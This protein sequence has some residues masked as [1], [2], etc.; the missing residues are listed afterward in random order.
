M[1]NKLTI[2]LPKGRLAELSMEYF[3][4]LGITSSEMEKESRKLVFPSDCGN[5]EFILVR[6]SDVPVY[7]EH[8]AA[9]MGVVGKDTLLEYGSDVYEP[10]DLGFG[11]CRMCIAK[12][13]DKDINLNFEEWGNLRVA[14]KFENVAK[15]Y[16][17]KKGINA[18]IIKLYGSIE[19]AP[20]LG[21]SDVIV[22][23]VSS[24]ATLRENGLEEVVTL[25]ESTARM[26][27]NKASM[28]LYY[29]KVKKLI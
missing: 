25:F 10:K 29:D 28:K 12:A 23:I 3:A 1:T 7:V 15:D 26:I 19:L 9:D 4:K 24:G 21:L 5:Y 8:G 2:A 22:D 18:E 14:T 27:V 20:I 11:Y 13:K 17:K 16:F 6:A